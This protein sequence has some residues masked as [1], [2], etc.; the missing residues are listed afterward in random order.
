MTA[1]KKLSHWSIALGM[2]IASLVVGGTQLVAEDLSNYVMYGVQ[3]DTD[4][5]IRRDFEAGTSDVIGTIQTK[6][7]VVLTGIQGIG[8]IPRSLNLYGIW[9]D[10]QSSDSQVVYI[11]S[12]T[13][14][15]RLIGVPLELEKGSVTAAT[16]VNRELVG[17][18]AVDVDDNDPNERP[19]F[20]RC[21]FAG[22]RVFV[23]CSRNVKRVRL[24]FDD[25]SH[26][27]VDDIGRKSCTVQG[28]GGNSGKRV[29]KCSVRWANNARDEEEVF[30]EDD[31]SDVVDQVS[32]RLDPSTRTRVSDL[33]NYAVYAVVKPN[34]AG[35]SQ[36]PQ[37]EFAVDRG[38]V[39]PVED[40]KVQF[41]VIGASIA[42]SDYHLPVTARFRVGNKT[43]E[44]WG[45]FNKAVTANLNDGN[46]PRLYIGTTNYS[47]GTGIS[48]MAQSWHKRRSKDSGDK[49]S[50][51]LVSM[52]KDSRTNTPNILLLR[53]GDPVPDVA[54][55]RDSNS[56]A[57]FVR[58]YVEDGRISIGKNDVLCLFE[59]GTTNLNSSEADFQDLGILISLREA[60]SDDKVTICHIPPGNPDNAHT[61]SVGAPA[62]AAHLAHGDTLGPC[63]GGG[64]DSPGGKLV[65]IDT[66]LSTVQ[67][68]MTLARAYTSLAASP[69]T[70]LFYGTHE[71][72]LY[73]INTVD[74]TE[75]RLGTVPG[76]QM[77]AMEFAGTGLFGFSSASDEL[78]EMDVDTAG[79]IGGARS[80]D[81][82]DLE[83]ITFMKS[84]DEVPRDFATVD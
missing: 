22:N 20:I 26:Q 62:V 10:P 29:V 43:I 48:V 66:R 32:D 39:I 11:N 34:E 36:E 58:G 9:T 75:V 80:V 35:V 79:Q 68:V 12:H 60:S 65:R 4:Q 6:E 76:S 83:S 81:A 25:G 30:D 5:L 21:T 3:K 55:F 15:A 61:L 72:D 78:M 70:G 1:R 71:D 53:D 67:N 33:T 31:D 49:D 8:A 69:A 2:L 38:E 45:N 24:H 27:D 54:G 56:M 14:T 82:V 52:S 44:P 63:D 84:V 59:L 41:K 7:G 23:N 28:N 42:N 19:K 13:A 17:S 47:S 40:F 46:N 18:A 74:G 16:A 50:H 37:V 64:N 73:V 51:W 77:N 57:E